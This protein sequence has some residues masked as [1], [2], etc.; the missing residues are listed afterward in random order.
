MKATGI[1]AAALLLLTSIG[2]TAQT[3][4]NVPKGKAIVEIYTNFHSGFGAVNDERGFDLT[5]AI[6]AMSCCVDG[7]GIQAREICKDCAQLQKEH[8]KR[9]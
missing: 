5:V 9:R 3:T 2:S 8:S 6:W 4:D 1:I 7:S